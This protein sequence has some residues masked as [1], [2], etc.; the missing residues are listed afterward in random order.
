[1]SV[2]SLYHVIPISSQERKSARQS[3][4]DGMARA[5]R[6]GRLPGRSKVSDEQ[7]RAVMHLDAANAARVVGLC[8]K[9]YKRRR[10]R[11]E[12]SLVREDDVLRD[13]SSAL[14]RITLAV[15]GEAADKL[16]ELDTAFE[17]IA[18]NAGNKP[19][20]THLYEALSRMKVLLDYIDERFK[21]IRAD[22]VSGG[23]VS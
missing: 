21:K 15:D 18:K 6:H 1:M 5:A 9:H 3:I 4:R 10:R 12:Q 11:L 23:P 7:I 13:I 20:Y 22:E 2:L 14:R 16:R 17:Q 8:A 19:H